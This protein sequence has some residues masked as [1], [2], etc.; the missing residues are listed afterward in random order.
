[1]ACSIN[2]SSFMS[3][4]HTEAVVLLAFDSVSKT[5]MLDMRCSCAAVSEVLTWYTQCTHVAHVIHAR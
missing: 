4:T 3:M 1:M 2:A 5:N